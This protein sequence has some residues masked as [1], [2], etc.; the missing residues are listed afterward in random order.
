[1]GEPI[2]LNDWII[3]S[4]LLYFDFR[5]L[6]DSNSWS[7]IRFQ[8]VLDD[9]AGLFYGF[10]HFLK[11]KRWDLISLGEAILQNSWI[12][13]SL[14]LYFN[15]RNLKDPNFCTFIGSECIL[16][17]SPVFFSGFWNFLKLKMGVLI[18]WGEPVLQNI[19]IIWSP[20]LLYF[21][22]RNLKDPSSLSFIRFQCILYD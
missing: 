22:F 18:S 13:W 11:L 2:L 20:P 10:W 21:N 1:M 6:K 8:C 9:S 12:V 7:F 14:L 19:C 3:S 17:E 4:P 16:Y 15:F 5:N